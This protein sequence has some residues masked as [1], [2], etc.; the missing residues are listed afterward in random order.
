MNIQR[1]W[2]SYGNHYPW[3][4]IVWPDVVFE[5]KKKEKEKKF[6]F[7]WALVKEQHSGG[8]PDGGRLPVVGQQAVAKD[9]PPPL[10][11]LQVVGPFKEPALV[12]VHAGQV[13]PRQRRGRQTPHQL[14][15]VF[16]ST[17]ALL[18][19]AEVTPARRRRDGCCGAE[20]P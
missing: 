17:G 9:E 11:T 12:G 7:K 3:R 6:Y 1:P 5:K 15:H 14:V 19:A 20:S 16:L 13:E 18:S 8:A 4:D 10:V 2:L